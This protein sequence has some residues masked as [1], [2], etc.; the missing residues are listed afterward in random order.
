MCTVVV[1]VRPDQILLAANRDERMDRP[2]DPPAAWWPDRPGII[3]GRDRTAGGTWMGINRHGV[4]A[5]VLNRPGTLGPAIG[6]RSRGDLPLMALEHPTATAAAAALTSLDASLWRGFNM[7]LADR[8]GAWFVRGVG[9]GYPSAERLPPGV[10][11]VTALDPND[12]DS[13]RTAAHLPRFQAAEP[14]WET[15]KA[16]LSDQSGGPAEQ[17][18]VEPRGGFGTVSSSFIAL[19][20][21]GD[22]IWL[23]AAGPPHQAPF[24]P[25]T[26]P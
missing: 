13:P 7:V 6:K 26:L 4:V 5:T 9:Y 1:L 8:S 10:S 21:E 14:D 17:L 2:W 25:V 11:M 19:P 16:I 22:P 20:A 24:L 18:N 3:A 15:W 12:M 23:F